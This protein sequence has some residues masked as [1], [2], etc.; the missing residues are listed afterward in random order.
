MRT[1]TIILAALA[2]LLQVSTSSAQQSKDLTIH[3]DVT[4]AQAIR[5]EDFKGA[6]LSVRTWDKPRVE[7][8]VTIQIDMSDD[9]EENEYVK[10]VKLEQDQS[11]GQVVIRL[12][13]PNMTR[14]FSFSD[15]FKLNF[16]RYIRREIRGEVFVPKANAFYVEVP[17]GKLDVEGI[18]GA[19]EI[20]CKSGQ[21]DVRSCAHLERI[22]N[23]YGTTVLEKSGGQLSLEN[24]SGRVDIK[25]FDGSLHIKAPYS[26]VNAENVTGGADVESQSGAVSLLTIG[27]DIVVDAPYSTIVA[28]HVK[29]SANITGKSGSVRVTD[30]EGLRVDAP[31][32]TIDADEVKG[33]AGELVIITGQSGRIALKQIGSGVDVQSPY[34]NIDLTDISGEVRLGTKSGT[35]RASNIKGNWTSLTEYSRITV[36]DL[37]AQKVL[38][39]NKSGGVEIDCKTVPD[40]VE[41][42]NQYADVRLDVP[43]GLDANVRLKAEYGAITSDLSVNVEQM[44]SGAIA[45]GKVGGGKGSVSIETKSGNIRVREK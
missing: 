15:I 3:A 4:A 1:G 14:G 18:A 32:S 10:E 37:S 40:A 22:T 29:G 16:K 33:M 8:R 7:V 23:D 36:S 43:K 17:Y 28:E 38:V 6:E 35:V 13:Q 5:L 25:T 27:A 19:V 30:V 41:I 26:T 12:V 20:A 11:D 39:E 45:M 31:Y 34:T 24:R 2:L 44:G 21:V 9:D 42:V